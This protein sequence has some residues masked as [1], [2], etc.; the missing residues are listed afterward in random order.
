MGKK[1][2]LQSG[3]VDM[4][5]VEVPETRCEGDGEVKSEKVEGAVANQRLAGADLE[6]SSS[7][8]KQRPDKQKAESDSVNDPHLPPPPAQGELF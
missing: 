3:R 2:K 8:A 6:S 7:D 4:V 5:A 1:E